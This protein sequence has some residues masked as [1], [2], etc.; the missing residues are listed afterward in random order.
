M[1][2]A[3]EDE[4]YIS[5]CRGNWIAAGALEVVPGVPGGKTFR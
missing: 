4:L 3:A 1:I 2:A 5:K